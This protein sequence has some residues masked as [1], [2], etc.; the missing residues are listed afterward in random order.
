LKVGQVLNLPAN[1]TPRTPAVPDVGPESAAANE[2]IYVVQSGDT[3][4]GLADKHDVTVKAI[5]RA[6]G[7]VGSNI[8]VGQRLII[9]VPENTGTR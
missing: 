8:R 1:V 9:P 2:M 6:N 7:I 3:L 5:Q 4:W